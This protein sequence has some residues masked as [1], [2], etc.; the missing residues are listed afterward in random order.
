MGNLNITNFAGGINEEVSPFL[1]KINEANDLQNV[2][3][4]D[5]NLSSSKSPIAYIENILGRAIGTL[6]GYYKNNVGYLLVAAGDTLYKWTGTAFTVISTGFTSD[7]FDYLNYNYNSEDVLILCNG[8]NNTKIYN[9]TTIRDLKNRRKVYDS[10]GTITSYVDGNGVTRATEALCTTLAPKAYRVELHYER[11][12]LADDK[13]LYFSTANTHG[14]DIEDFT[15]PTYPT[16]E[17]NQHGGEI[18]IYTND[19]GKIIGLNVSFDDVVIYKQNNIFKIYGNYPGQYQ[20]AQI[21][22]A[23]GGIADRSIASSNLGVYF[24]NRDNIYLYNG[25]K[26]TPISF[27][28]KNTLA[29]IN[30]TYE[31]L[32]AGIIFNG[33]YIL[34]VPE[35]TSTKNNLII[36]YDIYNNSFVLIR[37][38]E[39]SSFL[40]FDNKLLFVNDDGKIYQYAVSDINQSSYWLSG[41]MDL[42][43]SDAIKETEYFYFYAQGTGTIKVSLITENKT[44]EKLVPLTSDLKPY[45]VNLKAKGRIL[46]FKIENQLT[47]STWG[48]Y[49]IVKP[50]LTF[51]LDYD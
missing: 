40:V 10:N 28:V 32:S 15:A 22:S 7:K 43:K 45:R 37:G 46:Q 36:E 16:S 11:I 33:K 17:V 6:I 24:L 13:S 14:F 44:T 9:G 21:Y 50:M 26:V 12:W 35:G 5:G 51:D 34:A 48:N 47:G 23:I 27:K 39:V 41:K 31:N 29:N 4:N 42:D 3:V 30:L 49:T 2:N 20:K 25:T 38:F 18:S 1:L 8:V 19:G